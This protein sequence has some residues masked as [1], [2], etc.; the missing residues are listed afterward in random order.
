MLL[1]C[2]CIV[3]G[4]MAAAGMAQH[5]ALAPIAN[6]QVI[7]LQNWLN[8][9]LLESLRADVHELLR[10]DI[11]EVTNEPIGKRLKVELDPQDF[12]VYGEGNPSQARETI[13]KRL[14][15]LREDVEG[16]V[17]R[18]LFLDELGAQAKYTVGKIGQPVHW[19]IDQRHEAFGA[20]FY[21]SERTRRSIAWLLYLGHE[22]WGAPESSGRG[23]MLRA[24]PRPDAVGQCGVHQ[25]NLQV[26]WLDRG[27]GS[28]PVFL[29]CWGV[30]K[31]M[32]GRTL[33]EMRSEF[34]AKLEDEAEVWSALFRY[35]PSYTLYT[36]GT[37]GSREDVSQPHEAQPILDPGTGDWIGDDSPSL[38]AMLPEA[39]RA[40]FTSTIDAHPSQQMVE[41]NPA[42]GTLVVFDGV[43]V[44]HEVLPVEQGERLVSPQRLER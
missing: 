29:D 41:V 26:G 36:V 3:A 1:M 13:R 21:G 23:G 12:S 5:N 25:G 27:S 28:E 14:D 22:D 42:G 37:D 9:E 10:M 40:G 35:Q 17:G 4:D 6:G 16:V 18:R 20:R 19:H 44:P 24:Y 39:L 30:P 31:G 15:A 7:V 11:F 33:A 34:E 38:Q 32:T 2:M 43:A 8:Q